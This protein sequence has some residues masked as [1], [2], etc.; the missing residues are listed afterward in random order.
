LLLSAGHIA[1]LRIAREIAPTVGVKVESLL[2]ALGSN[3][4]GMI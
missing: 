1:S 2:L 3:A 4:T